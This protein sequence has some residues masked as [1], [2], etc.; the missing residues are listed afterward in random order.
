MSCLS[1]CAT[2]LTP[3]TARQLWRIKEKLHNVSVLEP[4][5]QHAG[6]PWGGGGERTEQDD[7]GKV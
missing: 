4:T 1:W 2:Y 7:V 3:Q 6:F 5:H